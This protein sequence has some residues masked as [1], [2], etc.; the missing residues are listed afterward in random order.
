MK[1]IILLIVLV[2]VSVAAPISTLYNLDDPAF[3]SKENFEKYLRKV[4]SVLDDYKDVI[5]PKEIYK[6]M[7]SLT[8]DDYEPLK[9]INTMRANADMGD[10]S[11]ALL[12]ARMLK[13]VHPELYKRLEIAGIGLL[14]RLQKLFTSTKARIINIF[15][16][17]N[18]IKKSQMKVGKIIINYYLSWPK[19]NKDDLEQIFPKLSSQ[20]EQ[21]F[22][23]AEED[24]TF[25]YPEGA[26][27]CTVEGEKPFLCTFLLDA[28]NNDLTELK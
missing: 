27:D 2:G 5:I 18:H 15:F 20:L 23:I 19:E 3:S 10:M 4:Q 12:K 11:G 21:L 22:E 8:V 24:R 25:K 6:L 7:K 17:V 13:A 1:T 14:R 28:A 26:I 9:M 16:L